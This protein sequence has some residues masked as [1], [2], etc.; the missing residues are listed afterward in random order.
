MWDV[1]SKK[2]LTK[3]SLI[4]ASWPNIKISILLNQFNAV[5]FRFQERGERYQYAFMKTKQRVPIL[6]N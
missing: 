6:R 3:E 2:N 1:N 4:Q 5:S